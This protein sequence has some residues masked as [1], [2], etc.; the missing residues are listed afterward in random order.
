MTLRD[1]F[2]IISKPNKIIDNSYYI[3]NYMNDNIISHPLIVKQ[4]NNN[5][6]TNNIIKNYLKQKRT[7]FRSLI[8]NKKSNINDINKFIKDYIIKINTLNSTLNFTSK[9]DFNDECNKYLYDY[10]LCSPF[11]IYYLTDSINYNKSLNFII[12]YVFKNIKFKDDFINKINNI[13]VQNIPIKEEYD[14]YNDII[15]LKKLNIYYQKSISLLDNSNNTDNTLN[16]KN[17]KRQLTQ[18]IS[19]LIIIEL[20]NIFIANDFSFIKTFSEEFKEYISFLRNYNNLNDLMY[21]KNPNNLY[22]L[23][24]F[25]KICEIYKIDDYYNEINIILDLKYKDMLDDFCDDNIKFIVNTINN[26]VLIDVNNKYYYSIGKYF[27]N[28][29]I[30]FA[31]LEYYLMKRIIYSNTTYET[32][33]KQFNIIKK[34]FN[35]NQY[36][37]YSKIINDFNNFEFND[38]FKTY[39]LSYNIWNLNFADGY[40][41]NEFYNSND[42]QWPHYHERIYLHLGDTVFNLNTCCGT[43]K[44]KCLPIHYDIINK[45]YSGSYSVNSNINYPNYPLSF[46]NKIEQQLLKSYIIVLN[47]DGEYELNN[48]YDK[49]DLNLFEEY[50]KVNNNDEIII[51]KMVDETIHDRNDIIV[52]NINSI[53]KKNNLE[54]N[55][56][57]LYKV[58]K[59][60]LVNYFEVSHELYDKCI[61]IMIIKNLIEE[62]GPILKKLLF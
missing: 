15:Y 55:K 1:K 44:I 34:I 30:F 45:I 5:I 20:K 31:H 9:I 8:K 17:I 37:K 36:Y 6:S 62:N 47:N 13:F 26:N 3:E 39:Y 49:G 12:E 18:E 58:I 60:A 57:D 61:K 16:Y 4:A 11:M 56:N 50:H 53:I 19:K 25:I 52:T 40:F 27:K 29:D 32:E 41:L 24:D 10:I 48:Y 38:N 42:E 14:M 2:A 54:Y 21:I 7:I 59:Q 43:Y 28:V 51:K 35:S 46:I 23:I 22:E 33:L